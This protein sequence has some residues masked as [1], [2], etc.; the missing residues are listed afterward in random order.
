MNIGRGIVRKPDLLDEAHVPFTVSYREREITE[1]ENCLK[2]A[3]SQNRPIHVWLFGR[4]GTGKTLVAKHVL[5][6]I[7]K[8]GRLGGIYINCWEHSTYYSVMDKL[9]RELRILGA[10][11]LNA[12][13]KLERFRQFVGNRPFVIILDEIDQPKRAERDSIIYHLGNIGNVG[14]VIISN[15]RDVVFSMDERIKSRL[16]ARHV[17]FFPYPQETIASMLKL[18]AEF[19]LSPGSCEGSAINEIAAISGGD[20]RCAFQ[21]LVNAARWAESG[22]SDI[23]K[24]SHVK[25]GHDSSKSAEKAMLLERL[26]SHHRLL[27]DLV[28]EHGQ[29]N[30]GELWEAYLDDCRE[31][32][33]PAI[34]LRTFSEYMNKLIEF[35]LVRWDR[36]LVRGKVRVFSLSP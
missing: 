22:N 32:D 34:A 23:I 28:K 35:D 29:I 26:S 19:A 2:P 27:Y 21:T 13:F 4:P 25:A 31:Q 11:K 14:L 30:S 36:A 12:S 1:L 8:S 6:K 15:S 16:N 3:L 5:Q 7:S 18:R 24:K 33:K 9:V 10:E 17:E 20:A